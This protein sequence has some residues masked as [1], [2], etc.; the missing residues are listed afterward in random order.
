M[1]SSLPE[2]SWAR[3]GIH[4]ENGLMTLDDLLATYARHGEN[5]ISQ[6]KHLDVSK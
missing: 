2:T 3:A 6:I 1:L 5:H 4:L